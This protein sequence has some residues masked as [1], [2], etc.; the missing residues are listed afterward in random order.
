[1]RCRASPT[2]AC[3]V[4]NTP[5]GSDPMPRR[6]VDLSIYLENDVHL[7][8]AAVRPKIEYLKHE[9][10]LGADRAILSRPQE[11]GPA[12]RR[13]LGR[14]EGHADHAQRHAPGRALPLPLDDGRQ[15]GGKPAITIDEVPLDWCFQP[16]R[17]AR[18]PPLRRRLRRHGGRR[19]SRARAHRP[20][21]AAAGHRRR[22]HARRLALRPPRLRQRRLRHGL[23]GDDVPAASAACA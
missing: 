1:M 8:S 21:V 9:D 6:F 10:T 17:E 2:R 4:G 20:R 11:R 16:G 22:Q 7:R 3:R 12:R 13:G 5:A 18:L 15:D 14:R 23:R 19:R